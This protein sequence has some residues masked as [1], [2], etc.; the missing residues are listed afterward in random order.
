MKE[1]GGGDQEIDLEGT[2][3][4]DKWLGLNKVSLGRDVLVK[5]RQAL[6]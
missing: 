2:C 3:N 5:T 6:A 4:K 1:E